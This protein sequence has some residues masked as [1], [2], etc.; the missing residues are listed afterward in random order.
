MARALYK[1]QKKLIKEYVYSF[2]ADD[3]PT[4]LPDDL[5]EKLK[6]IYDWECLRQEV[7]SYFIDVKFERV[8]ANSRAFDYTY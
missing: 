5:L 1:R 6:K 8:F 3:M 4:T 7:D 2:P